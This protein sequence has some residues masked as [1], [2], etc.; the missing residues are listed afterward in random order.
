MRNN[1]N[2]NY[3]QRLALMKELEE[4]GGRALAPALAGQALSSPIPRGIQQATG[5]LGVLGAFQ[6]AG[7]PEA[8][9]LAAASSPRLVGESAYYAGRAAGV[10][11]QVGRGLLDLEARLPEEFRIT[12]RATAIGQQLPPLDFRTLNLLYQLRQREEENQ[13]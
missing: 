9:A 13:Q 8:L 2:T 4:Q 12:P 7:T 1:V 5:P 10:P 6:V 11:G 3:G